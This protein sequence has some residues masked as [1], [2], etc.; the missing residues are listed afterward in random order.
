MKYR[1]QVCAEITSDIMCDHLSQNDEE[2]APSYGYLYSFI[3]LNI[4]AGMRNSYI[5]GF[6]LIYN[7]IRSV[8]MQ[9]IP[10]TAHAITAELAS[11]PHSPEEH[12]YLAHYFTHGGRVQ[13][14]LNGLIYRSWEEGPAGDGSFDD[15]PDFAAELAALP[16][17]ANDDAH[18]LV[19]A[20][21]GLGHQ[22]DGP[23]ND[24]EF[25]DEE[26]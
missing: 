26:D 2:E 8:L 21:I 1:L 20:S 4:R 9:D 13:H 24:E 15:V 18:T 22:F 19:R 6:A 17:C 11:Q 7:A 10:P 23:Y 5:R 3:P 25:Y 12:S 14:A 16:A